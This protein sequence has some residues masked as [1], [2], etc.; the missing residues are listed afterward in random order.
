VQI[1][2]V[3]FAVESFFHP[4]A[5]QFYFFCIGG[6]AVALQNTC[7]TELAMMPDESTLKEAA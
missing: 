5:Y 7:R 6:L 4:V 2:L 1:A 3:A